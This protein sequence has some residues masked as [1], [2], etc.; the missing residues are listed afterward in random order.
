MV[1]VKICGLKRHEDITYVNQLKPEYIGF[2]FTRS[3]RQ[4]SP[5]LARELGKNLD[6][7]IRKVGVFLNQPLEVVKKIERECG[8]DVLQFHGD[9]SPSYC[10][11]FDKEVWKS[12]P[13]KNQESL[14]LLKEYEV[15][16]YLLDTWVEGERGGTGKK[17]N[18]ALLGN[19]NKNK[20][21]VLAGGLKP[22]NIREAIQ[23]ARPMVVDVSSG[24][25]IN[26]CKDYGQ[27]K[28]FIDEVRRE[29]I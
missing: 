2:V 3:T 29:F 26:G 28:K 24:V 1:K 17:F 18:W 22:E 9:E 16:K 6:K 8:L 11:S 25:E 5:D 10:N 12:F 21:I 27:I 20:A 14:E 7:N 4:V 13:I 23:K 19:L 15:D